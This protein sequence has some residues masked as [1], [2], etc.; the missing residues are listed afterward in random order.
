MLLA[1]LHFIQ[2]LFSESLASCGVIDVERLSYSRV[3]FN[4]F[5]YVDAPEKKI[6]PKSIAVEKKIVSNEFG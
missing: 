4:Y 6:L 2:D 5:D 3:A 1:F